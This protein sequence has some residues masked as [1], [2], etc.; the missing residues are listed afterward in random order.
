MLRSLSAFAPA[1]LV[2]EKPVVLVM[3]ENAV[4]RSATA[5]RLRPAGFEVID[6][7]TSTEAHAVLSA[8]PVDALIQ[9]VQTPKLRVIREIS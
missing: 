6:V 9:L 7:A 2:A 8:I 4:L 1:A 5:K 3:E